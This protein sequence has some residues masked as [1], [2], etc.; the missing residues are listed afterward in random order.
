MIRVL[1]ADDHTVVRKGLIQIL[2]DDPSITI[3][4]EAVNGFEALEKAR[5]NKYNILILDISMPG[6]SGLEVL[7]QLKAE[8]PDLPVLVLSIYSAEQYAIRVIKDGAAGYMTKEVAPEELIVAVKR[9]TQGR[10]YISEELAEKLASYVESGG[11]GKRHEHLSDREFT[12]LL[13]ITSGKANKEIAFDLGLS[14]KTISTYRSRILEKM[15]MET[16]AQLMRY[17][18]NHNLI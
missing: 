8:I 7:Q 10:K 4:D 5:T 12:I 16:N 14:P 17:A 6:M 9:I 18:I 1:V 3:I 15:H 11:E 13:L 2:S